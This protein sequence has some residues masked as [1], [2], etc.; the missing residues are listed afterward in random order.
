VLS[1]WIVGIVGV[2]SWTILYV[3][4]ITEEEKM[5]VEEF[6]QQYEGYIRRSK[7]IFP[8]VM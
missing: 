5:M 8:K 6:G 7:R 3:V 1:N 4:R 2:L